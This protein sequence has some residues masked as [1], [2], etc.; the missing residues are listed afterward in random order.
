[1]ERT[2]A[3]DDPEVVQRRRWGR[4]E[5]AADGARRGASAL[6]RLISLITTIVVAIIVAGILLIVLKANAGN[7]IVKIVHDAAK[8]LAGPFDGMFNLKNPRTE[9]AVNWGIAAL[10]YALIGG[11]IARALRR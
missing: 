8:F 9:I 2:A 11:F 6:A 5:R 4:R 7:D 3:T 1:M 10:V